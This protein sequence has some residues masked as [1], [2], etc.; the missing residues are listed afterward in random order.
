MVNEKSISVIVSIIYICLSLYGITMEDRNICNILL[1]I[2]CFVVS[3]TVIII[4]SNYYNE[5]SRIRP[6]N[7]IFYV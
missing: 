3:G 7:Q 2:G 6:I 1:L 4:H 5:E